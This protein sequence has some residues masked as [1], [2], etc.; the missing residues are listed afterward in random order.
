M[1]PSPTMA[2]GPSGHMQTMSARM[3]PSP[4]LPLSPAQIAARAEAFL[5]PLD[6]IDVTKPRLFVDD[7][8]DNVR[9]AKASGWTAIHADPGGAWIG[10][11]ERVLGIS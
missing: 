10:E 8:I 2:I 11:A 1:Q 4:A 5:M 7:T 3:T 9:Q 6:Q